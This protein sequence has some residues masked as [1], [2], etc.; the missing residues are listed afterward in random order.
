MGRKRRSF[1]TS[2]IPRSKE[3]GNLVEIAAKR[4]VP[5]IELSAPNDAPA[6][7]EPEIDYDVSA[8]LSNKE[9]AGDRPHWTKSIWEDV[10]VGDFVK[11]MDN[12]QIPADILICSSSEDDNVAYVETKNLD[13][14]TNL[15]SR[16]AVPAL[17]HLHSAAD[18]ADRGNAF[19]VDCDSPDVNMYKLNAT[20]AIGKEKDGLTARLRAAKY[21]MGHRPRGFHG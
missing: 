15:K 6:N 10:R 4:G 9:G 7:N 3:G 1:F 8:K 13:G 5:I 16:H 21:Q 17:T 20:V 18:C 11:I 12:D 2:L 14:E 19:H